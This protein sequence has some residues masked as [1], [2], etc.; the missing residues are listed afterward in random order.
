LIILFGWRRQELTS[1]D[2]DE[3]L[4]LADNLAEED[5]MKTTTRSPVTTL[6]SILRTPE[7]I[8]SP[9]LEACIEEADG[10]A[11][12]KLQRLWATLHVPPRG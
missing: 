8:G 2:I 4:L 12:L 11:G 6:P 9:Y 5:L 3:A 7:D 1:K 10:D